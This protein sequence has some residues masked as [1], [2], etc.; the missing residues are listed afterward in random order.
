[1]AWEA[2]YDLSGVY[3]GEETLNIVAFASGDDLKRW[4]NFY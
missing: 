4:G 1:L 2:L 3:T